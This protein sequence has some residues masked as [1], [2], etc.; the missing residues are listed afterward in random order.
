MHT[1]ICLL[2]ALVSSV[3]CSF[4]TVH[5]LITPGQNG[6]QFPDN[7]FKYIFMNGKFCVSIWIWRKF[8]PTKGLI[9]NK[10]SN[11]LVLNRQQA[12]T[13]TNADSVH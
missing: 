2:Y 5:Q 7:I 1:F 3:L 8:V 6:C 11:G 9:D 4:N 13:W 10:P 12:I